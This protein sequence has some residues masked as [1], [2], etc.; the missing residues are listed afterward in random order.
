MKPDLQ[1]CL[2]DLA[3]RINEDEEAAL[4]RAW[5]RFLD[6]AH[7]EDV[8]VPPT[9]TPRPPATDWPAVHIN[10]ALHDPDLMLLQQ[11]GMVSEALARGGN[12][13]LGVRCNY[14]VSIM[15]SQFGC[16]VIEMPREQGDLP[17]PQC[18]D[19]EAAL[20]AA[21]DAG[22]PDLRT[23]QG[24]QVFDT[25][26]HFLEVLDRWPVLGR[27]VDLYHPDGQGPMDNAELVWGSDIFLAF[28]DQPDLVHAVLELMTEHYI[29]FLRA[30]FDLVPPHDDNVS[31]HWGFMLRGRI[32]LR[33]DSLMNLSP[34]LYTTF[35]RDREG[36]CLTE[37]GG[38]AIHFC[39]RGDHFI[40]AM[41]E[42]EHLY[43]INMS[44]PHLNDM[45]LIYAHTVDKGIP[46]IGFDSAAA[47]AAGRDLRGR[48]QCP[49]RPPAGVASARAAVVDH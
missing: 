45:E 3:R 12:A 18:L 35:I 28:Y 38:G 26:Q 46:L 27:W 39:G 42:I 48:V 43:A 41:S 40:T 7:D 2:D 31:S 33:D 16:T 9:R 21:V 10:D 32:V 11:F 37:L 5:R 36:R 6:D 49:K 1:R 29:T 23:G 20:R 13:V 4:H 25:A 47:G 15:A 8:F 19:G 34:E 24:G 14:G 22:V 44:Q 30:W 17:T